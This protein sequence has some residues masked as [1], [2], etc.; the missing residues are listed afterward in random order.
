MIEKIYRFTCDDCKMSKE[1]T[2][3]DKP[4]DYG[5]AVAHG[6]KICYCP[7]CAFRHRNTGCGGAKGKVKGKSIEGQISISEVQDSA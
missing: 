5:W 7:A 6:G 4:K 3:K 1:Y 2:N